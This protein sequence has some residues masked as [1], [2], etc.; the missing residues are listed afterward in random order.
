M[1]ETINYNPIIAEGLENYV[2]QNRL[3]LIA[4]TVLEGYSREYMTIQTGCKGA[5]ALNL[6]VPG[7]TIQTGGCGFTNTED[8]E[9]SQRIINA[10]LLKVNQAFCDKDLLKTW[11]QHEVMVAAGRE[12]LPFEQQFVEGVIKSINKGIDEMIWKGDSNV[13]FEGLIDILKK[14][15]TAIT[16]DATSASGAYDKVVMIYNAMP[17]EA[18]ADG[19]GVIFVGQDF[20]R[21]FIMDLVAKMTQ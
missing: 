1:A 2:E 16:V 13:N 12:K 17:T 19:D 7:A 9:L 6:L 20:Y 14:E 4:K 15:T 21:E 5:T 11:A 10:K 3:P 8:H 18:I